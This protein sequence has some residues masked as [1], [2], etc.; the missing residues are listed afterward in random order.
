[1]FATTAIPELPPEKEI[2]YDHSLKPAARETKVA[3]TIATRSARPR[4]SHPITDLRAISS[5][6]DDTVNGSKL[7]PTMTNLPSQP[8]PPVSYCASIHESDPTSLTD[9]FEKK[10]RSGLPSAVPRRSVEKRRGPAFL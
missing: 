9:T 5:C 10:T 4:R 3:P 1:M 7:A 2:P 6:N 8:R